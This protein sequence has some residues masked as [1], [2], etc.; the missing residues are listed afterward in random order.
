[1]EGT[2]YQIEYMGSCLKLDS[3]VQ[4]IENYCHSA[5]ATFL[6]IN[7]LPE[8]SDKLFKKYRI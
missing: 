2:V 3:L 6:K 4:R 5:N 7:P 8:G 1:M